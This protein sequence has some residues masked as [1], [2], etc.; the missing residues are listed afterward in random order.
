MELKAFSVRQPWASL[1]VKGVK[2]FEVR[3]WKPST[4]NLFLVH[5]SSNKADGI[6]ELREEDLFQEALKIAGMTNEK[7]WLKSAF[8]GALQFKKFW[9]TPPSDITEM[10]EYL[11]GNIYDVFLWESEKFWEF[12]RPI[13][14]HG[15]LNIWT[16]PAN[17]HNRLQMALDKAGVLS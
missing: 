4:G 15:K 9:D 7:K 12:D 16:P 5:A 1:L 8:V 14:C 6:R 13:P 11:C 3:T 2:R 10:D 17:L